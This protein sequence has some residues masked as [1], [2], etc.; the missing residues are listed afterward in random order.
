MKN[1]GD[2]FVK[3]IGFLTGSMFNIIITM[4]IIFAVFIYAQKAYVAGIDFSNGSAVSNI[5]AEVMVEIPKD[6]D[7]MGI[8]AILQEKGLVDNKYLFWIQARLNGTLSQ[9]RS[10]T[11]TLNTGMKT[12][13]I[14]DILQRMPE[15]AAT[16]DVRVTI[17][18]GYN[19]RQMAELLES[20]EFFS[21]EDFLEA[22]KS[23]SYNYD[24]LA[25]IKDRENYLEGYLFPSTYFLT[26]EPTPEEVITK[27]LNAFD[28]VFS[29]SRR[30]RAAELGYSVD[31]IVKIAS[32]IEREIRAPE[33]REL[34]S[35]VIHNRLDL[36]MRLEMDATV[37]YIL[38]KSKDRLL[39]S[40]LQIQSPYNTYINAGL[41]IGPISN[42]GEASIEAALYPASAPYLYYVVVLEDGKETGKHFFTDS[43]DKFLQAKAEYSKKFD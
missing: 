39:T 13:E 12:N 38:D 25:P 30:Q 20:K 9:F 21:A 29:F 10:G 23:T 28:N 31:D 19:I 5:P 3:V 42:P 15:F 40:D 24:F 36:G 27:M 6:T 14:M 8:A 34:G 7:A 26:D 32:I 2:T 1:A 41:P 35:A 17:P 18:E 43:Y 16:N 33:E 37:M 22:C 11:Y 4:V